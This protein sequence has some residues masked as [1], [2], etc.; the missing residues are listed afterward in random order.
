MK[1]LGECVSDGVFP[2]EPIPPFN[3]E[4]PADPK[5]G[6][7]SSNAAMIC[8]RA[9]RTAPRKIADEICARLYLEGTYFDSCEVAGAGFINF[10]LFCSVVFRGR[11]FRYRRGRRLRSDSDRSRKKGYWWSLYRQILPDLCI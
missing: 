11:S 10:F 9:F 1:A 3:V 5:N 8:A 4:I 6:D 2:A 7:L